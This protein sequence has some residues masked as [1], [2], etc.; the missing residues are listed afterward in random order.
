[1]VFRSWVAVNGI[2]ITRVHDLMSQPKQNLS[3]LSIIFY[4]FSSKTGCCS[5]EKRMVVSNESNQAK[6]TYSFMILLLK[7]HKI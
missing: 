3:F 4:L 7:W 6:F 5:L 2:E 1:M